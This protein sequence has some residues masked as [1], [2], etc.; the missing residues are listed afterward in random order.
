MEATKGDTVALHEN[1]IDHLHIHCPFDLLLVDLREQGFIKP[2]AQSFCI[3][4]PLGRANLFQ[5]P[6]TAMMKGNKEVQ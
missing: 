4:A 5:L 3:L 6:L 1:V 2:V